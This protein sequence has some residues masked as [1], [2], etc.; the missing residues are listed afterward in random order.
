MR[1]RGIDCRRLHGRKSHRESIVLSWPQVR[2]EGQSNRNEVE[3]SAKG[4][5]PPPRL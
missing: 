3:I 1:E 4:Q 2:T 5:S